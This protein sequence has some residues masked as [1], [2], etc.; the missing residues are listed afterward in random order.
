MDV[1]NYGLLDGIPEAK[2]MFAQL[3]EVQP[4][5]IIVGGNSSLSM[6]FDYVSQCMYNGAGFEPWA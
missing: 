6:M 4:E 3:L 1:R 2:K 5:N